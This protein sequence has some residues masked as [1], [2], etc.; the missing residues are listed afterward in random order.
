MKQTSLFLIHSKDRVTGTSSN[1]SLQLPQAI[2]NVKAIELLSVSIPATIYN[3]DSENNKFYYI[4][5][6]VD[7]VVTI[8]SASYSSTTIILTLQ[9]LM[10][11]FG[12]NTYTVTY[13]TS[14]YKIQIT[15]NANFSL[16]FGS[17]RTNSISSVLG[18]ADVDTVLSLTVMATNALDLAEPDYYIIDVKEFFQMARTTKNDT[19]TFIIPCVNLTDGTSEIFNK[20]TGYNYCEIYQDCNITTLNVTIKT[21]NNKIVNLNGSNWFMI[22]KLNY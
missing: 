6:G 3:I 2:K 4:D 20:N 21:H 14:T 16:R 13:N 1:Y 10:A 8:P 17:F 15:S 11:A 7:K 18:F 12:T 5:N 22:L 19:G 9:S